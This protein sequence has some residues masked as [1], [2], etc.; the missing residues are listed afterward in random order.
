MSQ[1]IQTKLN[2]IAHTCQ[3]IDG[4][5]V[6]CGY[7]ESRVYCEFSGIED[8]L[9]ADSGDNFHTYMEPSK[10][11]THLAKLFCAAHPPAGSWYLVK[12]QR[13]WLQKALLVQLRE[14]T[15]DGPFK[16]MVAGVASYVH[17]LGQLLIILQAVKALDNDLKIEVTFT[18]RCQFPLQQIEQFLAAIQESKFFRYSFEL[19]DKKFKCAKALDKEVRLYQSE[20]KQLDVKYALGDLSSQDVFPEQSFDLITEHFMTS[21]LYKNFEKIKPIRS[22]YSHWL[23]SNGYLFSADGIRADSP[24]YASFLELNSD[25][26]LIANEQLTSPVWDPYGLPQ[27][28]FQAIIESGSSKRF[29]VERDNTLS[30]FI[31]Q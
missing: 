9:L 18:D 27:E 5:P 20:L 4:K 3:V 10:G 12:E 31:K 26:G 11:A 17:A 24:I 13:E 1:K 15:G 25:V 23:K 7:H 14:H 21:L 19:G 29:P 28:T 8:D 16:I 30:G 22:N 2:D 6:P